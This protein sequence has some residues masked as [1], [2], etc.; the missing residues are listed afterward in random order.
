MRNDIFSPSCFLMNLPKPS[1]PVVKLTEKV[2]AKVK[3]Y[4]KVRKVFR[5]R[6]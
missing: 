4:P 6:E 2:Y 1:G 3:E 5:Y